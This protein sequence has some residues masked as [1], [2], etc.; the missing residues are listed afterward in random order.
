MADAAAPAVRARAVPDLGALA[1]G[2]AA[3][4]G[5]GALA[6]A[7]GG[8][9]P[10]SWGWT[11]LVGLWLAA[12]WLRLG[13]L[14]AAFLG[15]FAGLAC[16]TWLSLLWTE[17]SVQTVVEGFRLLAYLGATAALVLVVRRGTAPALLRGLLAAITLV[18]TYGLATRL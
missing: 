8:Y 11:A 12:A 18:C 7:D 9:F 3:A 13:T 2:V 1:V 17:N 14:G 4:S 6:A 5:M 16:W 15:A 10:P